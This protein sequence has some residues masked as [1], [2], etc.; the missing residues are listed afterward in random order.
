MDP[1]DYSQ[2]PPSAPPISSI[3]YSPYN[4]I[5]CIVCHNYGS[6]PTALFPC[7]CA[8]PI[9]DTCIVPWQ[10]RNETCPKCNKIWLN[11]LPSQAITVNMPPQSLQIDRRIEATIGCRRCFGCVCL[12]IVIL[13]LTG[14]IV[15]YALFNETTRK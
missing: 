14:S 5:A 13:L 7:G 4:A 10:M 11:V 2:L 1:V 6:A 8:H 9:H 12:I 3:V 15:V